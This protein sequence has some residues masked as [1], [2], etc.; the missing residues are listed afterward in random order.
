[1]QKAPAQLI[2]SM[3]LSGIVRMAHAICVAC[4]VRPLGAWTKRA[5]RFIARDGGGVLA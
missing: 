3:R 1:V 2:G 4:A 5:A